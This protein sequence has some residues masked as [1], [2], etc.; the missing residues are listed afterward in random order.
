VRHVFRPQAVTSGARLKSLMIK[1]VA[2]RHPR[3]TFL[4]GA[5]KC[6]WGQTGKCRSNKYEPD[7]MPSS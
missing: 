4:S 5:A 2:P 3:R 6:G 1:A 7:H